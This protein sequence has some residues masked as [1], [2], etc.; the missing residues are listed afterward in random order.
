MLESGYVPSTLTSESMLL[1]TAPR[2]HQVGLEHLCRGHKG[3]W[4]TSHPPIP[5]NSGV[6]WEGG[7]GNAQGFGSPEGGVRPGLGSGR[8]VWRTR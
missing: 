4:A 8:A 3:A 7:A 5:E 2:S 1:T 6:T